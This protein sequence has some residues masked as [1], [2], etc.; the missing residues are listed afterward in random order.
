MKA[1]TATSGL[2][3]RVG[4]MVSFNDQ[5]WVTPFLVTTPDASC[6]PRRQGGSL[7]SRGLMR[8]FEKLLRYAPLGLPM[9]AG[10]IPETEV[11]RQAGLAVSRTPQLSHPAVAALVP[12][13]AQGLYIRASAATTKRA[14]GIVACVTHR[15][16]IAKHISPH[17]ICVQ[18]HINHF[19]AL[20]PRWTWQANINDYPWKP[21]CPI[22]DR[23][24]TQA[25][26]TPENWHKLFGWLHQ[27]N[28][29]VSDDQQTSWIELAVS[30]LFAGVK[31]YRWGTRHAK[32]ICT[33]AYENR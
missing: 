13:S 31:L 27:Q 28:W 19:K 32:D 22:I 9:V 20:L 8:A 10:I 29:K 33:T 15:F 25:N 18:H 5:T 4:W 14:T 17:E 1:K 21:C 24:K 30:C 6:G 3:L 26:I 23:P 7:E 2:A 16:E 12:S 11:R